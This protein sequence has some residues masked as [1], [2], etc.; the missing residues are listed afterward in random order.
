MTIAYRDAGP[1]DWSLVDRLFRT[2]FCETFAHLYSTEDLDAF[3]NKFTEEAWRGEL[4]DAR[5]AFRIAE[6]AGDPVGY[7]KLGPSELPVEAEEPSIEL[8]QLYILKPW[9]GRG[10]ADELMRWALAMARERGVGEM[11]LTVYT[12][13]HRA[14][15]FY[16]RYAF[17]YVGPYRF[18]VGQHADE[19]IIMRLKL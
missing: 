3:L 10:I 11:Y 2:G 12:D 19:D 1:C 8:R 15:R 5:Y 17:S 9:H 6:D 16:E 18:M 14:R 7:V 13:N 4:A